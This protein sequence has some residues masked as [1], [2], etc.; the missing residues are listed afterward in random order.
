[1]CSGCRNA[2]VLALALA[3]FAGAACTGAEATRT[4]DSYDAEA[5][6]IEMPVT[7]SAVTPP[8]NLPSGVNARD[9][10]VCADPN[11][12]PFSN[13]RREGLENALAEL[14]A[15]ELDKKVSYTW[16]AQR[17][18]FIRNTLR[19]GLCDVVMGMPYASELTLPT[20]PYYRSTYVFATR[21]DRKLD[22]ASFDDPQLRDLVVGVHMIGD[23]YAN[24]PPAH[25]LSNRGMIDNIRGYTVYGDYARPN[26]PMRLV[27]AVV[28]GD[29]D[30]AVVW[31]PFAGW[32]KSRGAPLRLQPVSPQIDQPFLPFVF[33]IAVG[34]RRGDDSLR[35]L[36][37]GVL[38]RRQGD[39]AT[40][41]ASY[42]IP[43]SGQARV[44]EVRQ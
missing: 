12:M 2:T 30:V 25:A 6:S 15:A 5:D 27:D 16:W 7:P 11:N 39:I 19:S 14:V 28:D 41:V 34:V 26:P 32:A 1:M 18:G 23:D 20:R 40:L 13:E 29:I 8:A 21:E 33:D 44:A 3:L 24:S 9:L 17:R 4:A 42:G 43:L 22:I 10:R 35:T 31:G 38:R 37:D 36:L